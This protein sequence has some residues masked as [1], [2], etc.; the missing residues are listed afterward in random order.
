MRIIATA[1]L[2]VL[3]AGGSLLA[4]SSA[5]NATKWNTIALYK[6][7]EAPGATTAVD[8]S[9]TGMDATIGNQVNVGWTFGSR[10]YVNFPSAGAWTPNDERLILHDDND[11]LDPGD[12]IYRV[13]IALRTRTTGTNIVQKGQSGTVG[14]YWKLE[15]HNGLA[16]CFFRGSNGQ[17]SGVGSGFRIDDGQWHKIVCTRFPDR[18]VM[19]VDGGITGTRWAPSGTVSNIKPLSIGGKAECGGSVGCD[20][21]VGDIDYLRISKR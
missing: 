7:N 9:G 10:T 12:G 19:R 6:L 17:Q 14:G 18:T 20:Y 8:S 11:L 13:A 3:L 2:A 4:P 16:S 1:T 5:A 21:F 15:V